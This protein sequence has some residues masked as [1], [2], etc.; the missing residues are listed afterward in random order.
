MLLRV[1]LAIL[2]F[3]LVSVSASR[4][5][6]S[7]GCVDSLL[8]KYGNPC[9]L[10]FDPVCGC[11]NITYRNTCN[12]ENDGL[13]AWTEGPCEPIAIDFNPNPVSDIVF[14]EI[15]LREMG[16]INLWVYDYRGNEYYYQPFST[17]K[18][19]YLNID[20]NIWPQGLYYIIAI[21]GNGDYLHK[22]LVKFNR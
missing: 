6:Y 21:N 4:A 13:I 12:A 7:N 20:V 22:K 19:M 8:I 11:N 3:S 2:F 1:I 9:P 15:E 5:Q 10:E 17:F 16:Y 18:E 14:M